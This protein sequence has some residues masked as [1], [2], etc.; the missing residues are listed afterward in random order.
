V[1]SFIR[2]QIVSTQE[3]G[4]RKAKTQEHEHIQKHKTIIWI[5]P[6][7]T[8]KNTFKMY[9]KYTRVKLITSDFTLVYFAFIFNVQA[10]DL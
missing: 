6:T 10:E 3:S 2:C 8:L 4:H 7:S 5:S 9:V 1:N